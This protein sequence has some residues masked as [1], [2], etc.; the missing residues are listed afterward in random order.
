MLPPDVRIY[1]F[2]IAPP[3]SVKEIDV[4]VVATDDDKTGN[5]DDEVDYGTGIVR[6]TENRTVQWSVMYDSTRK[7]YSYRLCLHPAVMDPLQR[8]HRWHPDNRRAR[9]VDL[10]ELRRLLRM[11][12]GT[13]DFRAFAGGIE[14]LEKKQ[15]AAAKKKKIGGVN[16]VRTVYS[17]DLVEED[18]A[19]GYYRIDF[20]LKGALYKQVRN[21]VGTALE[22]ARIDREEENDDGNKE[23]SRA[24]TKKKKLLSESEF[25]RLLSGDDGESDESIDDDGRKQQVLRLAR[26]NNPCKPAPPQGLTLEYVFFDDDPENDF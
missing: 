26:K 19:K 5:G 12:E 18:A 8:R 24:T 14:Q 11:Y 4:V 15:T 22:A 7:L 21:M 13:R 2:G 9:L 6:V 17:V 20:M 10:D 16:T 25:R 23:K 3:P 1:N